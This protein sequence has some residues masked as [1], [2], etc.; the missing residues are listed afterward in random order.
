MLFRSGSGAEA[1][2]FF[3]QLAQ[4]LLQFRQA[5]EDG[6]GFAPGEIIHRRIA[7]IDGSGGDV[8]GNAALRGER[9]TIADREMSS[10]ADPTGENHA[11]ADVR[12]ARKP[13]LAAEQRVLAD[14]AS[15]PDLDEVVDFRSA[16]DLRLADGGAVNRA[17]RL[18]FDV[19][20]NHRDSRL[21]HFF[22]F[23]VCF[24]REAEAVAADDHS[25]LQQ[26]AVS[27]AAVLADARVRVS[28]EIVADFRAAIDRDEAVQ[29]GVR[30]DLDIFGNVAVRADVCAGSY[31]GGRSDHSG[32]MDTG[33]IQ[34]G[35]AHV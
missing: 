2:D 27:D 18:N 7:R 22:P 5:V 3:P 33:C 28:E 21:S 23:P 14:F 25:V 31:F 34:I 29:Y 15:V 35:R 13:N 17:V 12:G 6:D 1:G 11:I 24:S 4:F 10:G 9:G 19:V 26:D 30:A 20:A 8:R 32:S 16:A